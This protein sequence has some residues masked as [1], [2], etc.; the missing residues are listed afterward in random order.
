[1]G[2]LRAQD[3]VDLRDLRRRAR[4]WPSRGDPSASPASSART[5]SWPSALRRAPNVAVRA[6]ASLTA[7]L[8]AFYMSRLLFLTFLGQFRGDA[9]DRSTTSTSRRGRCW[10]RWCCSPSAQRRR[11]LHR[12]ARVRRARCSA[13]DAHHER[14]RRAGCRSS[15]PAARVLGIVARVLPLRRCPAQPR[16]GC[17]PRAAARWRGVL[18]AQVR[19]RRRLR[20]ASRAARSSCGQRRACSGSGV[21]AR[22]IDGSVNGVGARRRAPRA[23]ACA[24]C[25][26]ASCAATRC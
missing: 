8:T 18:E 26:R 10:C 21:D 13:C 25:R 6:S 1:M 2:G 4:V 7:L 11:R 17:R 16:R 23:P 20:L 3:P 14:A 19:L 9:R 12:H 22:L 24:S 5:R 15:P